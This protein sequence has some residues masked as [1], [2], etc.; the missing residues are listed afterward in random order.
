MSSLVL[1]QQE[2]IEA[3]WPQA[4]LLL[5]TAV[6][7]ES[8]PG[9]LVTLKAHTIA[10]L[11]QLWQI[12]ENETIEGYALTNVY[13]HNGKDRIVQ[14]H[15]GA[16]NKDSFLKHYETFEHWAYTKDI[17]IIEIVGRKAWGRVLAPYG[18]MHSYSSFTKR[19]TRE[20]H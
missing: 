10:G 11:N 2:E 20:L 17:S 12:V 18:F 5:K 8:D 7:E 6:H 14:I 19:I 16:G 4:E 9:L 3:H 1:L 13:T 15:Y